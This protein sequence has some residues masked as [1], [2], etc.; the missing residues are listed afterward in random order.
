M[1]VI[2]SR[3]FKYFEIEVNKL[4][5]KGYKISSTS[6]S[7]IILPPEPRE[8]FSTRLYNYIA[9]LIKER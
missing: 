8:V 5:E 2:E 7:S 6:S 4:I 3:D 1:K 9:I